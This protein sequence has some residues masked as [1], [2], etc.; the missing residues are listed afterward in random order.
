MIF[1]HN[2]NYIYNCFLLQNRMKSL[3]IEKNV[4][5]VSLVLGQSYLNKTYTL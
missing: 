2:H 5:S 4:L 3:Q 1:V